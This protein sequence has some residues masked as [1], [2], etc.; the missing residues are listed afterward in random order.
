M[1][2]ELLECDS[3]TNAT[4]KITFSEPTTEAYGGLGRTYYTLI[5]EED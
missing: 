1:K 2:L 5:V 3:K 4:W